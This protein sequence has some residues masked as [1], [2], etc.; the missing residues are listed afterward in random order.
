MEDRDLNASLIDEAD[1]L[2]TDDS[3]ASSDGDSDLE[4]CSD[5]EE[6]DE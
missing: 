6:I 2:E 3:D 4:S 1:F 5:D